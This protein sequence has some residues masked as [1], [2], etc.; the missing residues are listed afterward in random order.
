MRDWEIST[1]GPHPWNDGHFPS[2]ATR[3]GGWRSLGSGVRL[4]I[5]TELALTW[6]CCSD[7]SSGEDACYGVRREED[8]K[9]G[10]EQLLYEMK[11]GWNKAIK[12]AYSKY[13]IW[14]TCWAVNISQRT[15][16]EIFLCDTSVDG[17]FSLYF[18]NRVSFKNLCRVEIGLESGGHLKPAGMRRLSAERGSKGQSKSQTCSLNGGHEQSRDWGW[19]EEVGGRGREEEVW[20]AGTKTETLNWRVGSA[21]GW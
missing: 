13:W 10:H 19:R 17:I 1:E 14:Q 9:R 20:T 21:F 11:C 6:I 12:V 16:K 5:A 8:W 18:V 2:S 15:W 3:I 4:W 7:L